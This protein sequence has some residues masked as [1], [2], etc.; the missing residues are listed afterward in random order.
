MKPQIQ[1]VRIVALAIGAAFWSACSSD[2]PN[3]PVPQNVVTPPGASFSCPAV[4]MAVGEVRAGLTG[5]NFC[6][7]SA[8]ASEYVLNGLFASQVATGS[9]Q[10]SLTGFGITTGSASASQS[11]DLPGRMTTL[12]GM[13]PRQSL[14]LA[15][16]TF[17]QNVLE[18]RM[19]GARAAYRNRATTAAV[20]LTVGAAVTLNGS[21]SGCGNPDYRA[22]RVVAVSNKAIVVAD[23]ANPGGGFTSAEYAAI[24]TTFDTLVDPLDRSAF[25]DPTDIDG[26]SRV[27]IFFTRK[28]NELTPAGSEGIVGGFFNPRDLFPTQG[29]EA[30]AGS[31]FAE[32]FYM[33]VPDPTGTVN[34]NVRSKASVLQGTVGV[35]AHEY[36][37]L[38]NAARRIYVNNANDFEEIWLNEG[39]SHIAEE[40][41]FYR[42]SGLQPRANIDATTLT[43]SQPRV[44]AFNNYQIDNFGRYLKFL[45]RPE[46]NAPYAENDSL[47][48]RGAVWS[49]LRYAADRKATSDGTIWKQLVDAQTSGMPNLTAVFGSPIMNWFRDWSISVYTDDKVATTAT[50]QQPSWNFRTIYP[51]MGVS[52]FPLKMRPLSNGATTTLSL[53][54]GGSMYASFGVAAGG[55]AGVTWTTGSTNVVFSIVRVK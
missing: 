54:G 48:N 29:S 31:N 17:E 7:Q 14:E 50:F 21:S 55:T 12:D 27:I 2:T 28:V 35:I 5:T 52:G 32:M 19:A 11:A 23:D 1:R 20:P 4:E 8:T 39:L 53:N 47:A 18:P 34:N 13:T 10:V 41:L 24:A 36:Q 33:L 49:F 38:I 37:H 40:L 26:N 44:D 6:L 51:R 16:R 30:C 3:E 43:A 45:E 9:T 22:S 25:G 42:S 15:F 46:T